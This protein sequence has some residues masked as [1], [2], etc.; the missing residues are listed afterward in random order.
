MNPVQIGRFAPSP[1]GPLHFGSLVAAVASFLDARSVGGLWRLRIDDLDQA[2]STPGA[3]DDILRTLERFGM[4]WDGAVTFQSAHTPRY[5]QIFER[6]RD[7]DLVFG[8]VC[9][10]REISDSSIAPDGARVYPGRCRSGTPAGRAVRAWRL[11]ATGRIEFDDLIQGHQCETLETSVGDFVVLR[12]DGQFAYQLAVVVDDHDAGINRV[13]RGADLLDSTGR[14]I[15]L[16]QLLGYPQPVYAHVPVAVDAS[17]DKLSKQT[18]AR[19]I[20]A[21]PATQAL[22]AAL[23]FL[24]QRPPLSLDNADLADIWDWAL[25]HWTLGNI[26]RHRVSAAP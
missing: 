1:T 11:R 12:A 3:T 17:G 18:R 19:A 25:H 8:C 10:R 7:A 24:G 26:P 6:L 9:S 21:W 5:R 20:D 16:Q 15:Y 13:V 2:R 4:Q 14:Q 22:I 23:R